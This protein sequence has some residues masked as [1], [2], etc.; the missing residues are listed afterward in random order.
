MIEGDILNI[1]VTVILGGWHGDT[2][3]MFFVG[4]HIPVKAR[5]LVDVTYDAMPSQPE[6]EPEP[7]SSDPLFAE[8]KGK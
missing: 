5:R 6:P 4:D 2:S 7:R 1:D 3:R 8:S